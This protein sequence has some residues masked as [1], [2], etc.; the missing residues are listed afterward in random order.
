MQEDKRHGGAWKMAA[1]L[2]KGEIRYDYE[3]NAM[4]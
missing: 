4:A 2:T 3:K 1:P